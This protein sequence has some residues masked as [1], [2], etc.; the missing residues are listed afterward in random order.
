MI[1]LGG[2]TRSQLR[3]M[4]ELGDFD[5]LIHP[6]LRDAI[7]ERKGGCVAIPVPQRTELADNGY[8]EPFWLTQDA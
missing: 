3:T 4:L 2:L 7:L 6:S 1:G 8:P 5:H